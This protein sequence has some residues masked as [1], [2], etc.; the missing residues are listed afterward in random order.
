MK[1][2]INL[3]ILPNEPLNIEVPINKAPMIF[4]KKINKLNLKPITY[5]S[6]DTGLTR[7]Y[8]PGAQ[9]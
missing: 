7:H 8:P 5:V 3:N 2:N 4:N 9:E 1:K 6:N